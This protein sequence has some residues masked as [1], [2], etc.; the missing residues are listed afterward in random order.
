MAKLKK[1]ERNVSY[2]FAF[3]AILA[4]FIIMIRG[5]IWYQDNLYNKILEKDLKQI[6]EVSNY[7]TNSI[8]GE[9][10][11]CISQLQMIEEV[12][13]SSEIT[14]AKDTME[15]LQSM[16]A[17]TAFTTLGLIDLSGNITLTSGTFKNETG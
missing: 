11:H 5:F 14:D 10:Y 2:F 17:E 3:S 15:I 16:E 13:H 1:G 12:F 6:N 4:S 8:H 9:L 7:V